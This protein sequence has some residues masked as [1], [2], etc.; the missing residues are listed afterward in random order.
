MIEA[1]SPTL[2]IPRFAE[3]IPALNVKV[4]EPYKNKTGTKISLA[5][6]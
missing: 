6:K 3:D 2:D 1:T 4:S 5:I